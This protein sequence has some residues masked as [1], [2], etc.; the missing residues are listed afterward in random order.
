MYAD[1]N[2]DKLVCGDSGE[3]TYMY[4]SPSA[5]F[6]KSH[7]HETPWVLKDWEA[8]T[9]LA[10]KKTAILDGALYP[11]TKNLKLYRCLTVR[12][13][14]RIL[15][16]YSCVDSMNCKN[17]DD[18]GAVM[19]KKRIEIPNPAYRFVFLDDGGDGM[20]H[21]GGWTVYVKTERWWDPPPIRH[22]DGTNF[23]YADGHSDYVKW[24]DQRTIKFGKLIPPRAQS[25][26]Q[27]GNEDIRLAALGMWGYRCA[28]IVLQ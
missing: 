16:T 24:N 15:R 28:K 23:S 12:I 6:N 7:Y 4:S 9:T 19:L 8:N 11:Y 18:M 10:Q 22:G 20:A 5:P 3:Y 27:S 21:M 17:W 14:E 25:D 13:Q 2:G 26:V 1:E